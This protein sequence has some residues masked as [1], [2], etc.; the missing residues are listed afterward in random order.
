MRLEE[1]ECH[2]LRKTTLIHLQ[3]WP[4]ND[5]RTPGKVDTLTKKVLSKAPLLTFD[6]L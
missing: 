2:L 5:N 4:D 3:V 6:D 1:L